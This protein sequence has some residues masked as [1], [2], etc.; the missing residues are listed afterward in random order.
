MGDGPEGAFGY[1]LP[2]ASF[3]YGEDVVL[4]LSG[5]VK[6]AHNLGYSST[7]ESLLA[8]DFGLV[9]ANHKTRRLWFLTFGSGS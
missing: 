5:Q 1:D 7:G 3:R 8:G 6:E 4:D 9:A 2:P